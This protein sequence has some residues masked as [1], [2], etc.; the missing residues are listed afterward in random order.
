MRAPPPG[1]HGTAGS[2]AVSFAPPGARSETSGTLDTAGGWGAPGI[3]GRG[4]GC[5]SAPRSAQDSARK[6]GVVP[7]AGGAADEEELQYRMIS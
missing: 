3:R 1:L 6:G 2:W 5:R 7:N 4:P